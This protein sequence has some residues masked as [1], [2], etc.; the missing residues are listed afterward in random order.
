MTEVR[1]TAVFDAWLNGLRD[2][3]AKARILNRVDRL[4][5]G[6]PGDM[7]SIGSGVWELRIDYGPGYRLYFTKRGTAIVLLLC[8]GDKRSQVKDIDRAIAMVKEL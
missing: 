7:K 4:T 1:R 8:G 3:Q 2:R 6:N 5:H